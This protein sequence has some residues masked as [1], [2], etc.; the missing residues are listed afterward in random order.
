MR[1][2]LPLLAVLLLAVVAAGSAS[3]ARTRKRAAPPLRYQLT[4]SGS[5]SVSHSDQGLQANGG[6]CGLGASDTTPFVD[7]Y[8]LSLRWRTVFNATIRRKQVTVKAR[9]TSVTA[10]QYSY[11][12]YSYDFNCHQILY[13][14]QG[15]PCTGTLGAAGGGLMTARGSPARKPKRLTFAISP[16]GVLAAT[17]SECTVD[18]SPPVTYAA[19]DELGLGT[20]GLT[21]AQLFK[22]PVR[23]R[24]HT[25]AFKINSSDNCAQ[26]AQS[27]GETETCSTSYAGRG[28]LR[29]R[30][31]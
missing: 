14:P 23:K 9:S 11:Q 22:P 25:Y 20:L 17:P 4:I 2:G 3:A 26:P 16:F 28:S 24:A 12:G 21:V 29:V 8:T 30:P 10:G 13:G 6:G 7:Q 18:S 1:R 31:R 5:L 15:Q 27:P 19:A